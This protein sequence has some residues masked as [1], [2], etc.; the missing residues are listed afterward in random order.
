MLYSLLV[1]RRNCIM[2]F[3]AFSTKGKVNMP[4]GDI[5]HDGLT[6]N[7]QESFKQLCDGQFGGD[8]LAEKVSRAVWK[9][10]Q[11]GGEELIQFLRAVAEQCE[12][13]L[14]R[15]VFGP[16]Y[17]QEQIDWQKEFTRVDELARPIH[18]DRRFKTLAVEACKEQLE[19]LRH[20]G[21][22]SNC[23]IELLMK[24]TWNIYIA[25]F[26]ARVPLS[27]SCYKEVSG[28]FVSERLEMMRPYVKEE[29]LRYVEQLYR[30]GTVLAKPPRRR[31]RTKPD[32]DI[33]TDLST[34][35]V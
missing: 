25:Q 8:I 13:I 11:H 19:D 31:S 34:I 6:R 5:V 14:D 33:D 10:V 3:S 1:E 29:L 21:N 17:Q 26:E 9:D 23:H 24:Y 16:I 12:H 22:P 27:P 20:G 18:A 2:I 35:G 30:E 7:Y 4:D 15:Y 28:K 32:Y